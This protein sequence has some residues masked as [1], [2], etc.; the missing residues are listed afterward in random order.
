MSC[1]E[2]VAVTSAGD[3][4]LVEWTSLSRSRV[5]PSRHRGNGKAST[6][7]RAAAERLVST[8][9]E[10]EAIRFVNGLSR[11]TP[12]TRA[13]T[14]AVLDSLSPGAAPVGTHRPVEAVRCAMLCL[15]GGFARRSDG[16]SQ[17][18]GTRLVGLEDGLL[19][20]W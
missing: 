6:I 12:E 3:D 2:N 11:A 20:L 14:E 15:H 16:S 19:S 18:V 8:G 4:D 1:W 17:G 10:A 5:E 7:S 13:L 9:I